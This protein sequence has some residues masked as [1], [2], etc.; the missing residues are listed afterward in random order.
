MARLTL[1]IGLAAVA[2]LASACAET[3]PEVRAKRNPS[4]YSVHQPVVQRTDLVLDL[5]STGSGLQPGEAERLRGWFNSLQ[6]GYGDRIS[7]DGGAY[8]DPAAADD[9]AAVA[10]DYGMLLSEG[11]APLTAGAVAPGAVRVVVTRMRASVP[12]CPDWAYAG[13][14]GGQ[15]TTESNFGCATNSNLAAMIA[16]PNDLVLG[17]VGASA[18]NSDVGSKAIKQYRDR[19]PTGA[20]GLKAESSGGQ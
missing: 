4:L 20:G 10:A 13:T 5:A 14:S 12:G 6:L 11:G 9:V 18:P 15:I 3:I 19:A 7:I 8:R 2:T 16:D 17:Q 1:I